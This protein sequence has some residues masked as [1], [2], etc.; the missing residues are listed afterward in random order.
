ML[1]EAKLKL[2]PKPKSLDGRIAL[3]TGGAGGI[4][5]ATARRL[6]AEDAHVVIT[7]IDQGALEAAVADLAQAHG[8]D[9]V[10]GFRC[11]VTYGGLGARRRT[12]SPPAS[13]AGLDIAGQQRGHRLRRRPSRRPPSSC[14]T[15][16]SASSPP[17]TSWSGAT[18]FRS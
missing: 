5:S 13:S 2:L 8:R 17:A 4:G 11:D 1:E 14:G 15:A 9:R 7:D 10:R 6:L 12:R 3:V 18:A 16:T